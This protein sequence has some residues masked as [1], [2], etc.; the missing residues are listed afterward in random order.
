MIEVFVV[1]YGCHL[2]ESF[3][4]QKQL[5]WEKS[6]PS[7]SPWPLL[8]FPGDQ[9][10]RKSN[11]NLTYLRPGPFHPSVYPSQERVNVWMANSGAPAVPHPRGGG[12]PTEPLNCFWKMVE[13]YE[14][15]LNFR[16]LE[17]WVGIAA[18][19]YQ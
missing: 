7:F 2:I 10:Y 17:S 4:F 5:S 8:R 19:S 18:L 13:H 9:G 6:G 12:I 16:F 14:W 11:L 1:E 3:L 15:G